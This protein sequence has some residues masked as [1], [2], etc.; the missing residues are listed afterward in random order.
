VADGVKL[1]GLPA[2]TVE[3]G[4]PEIVGALLGKLTPDGA[5]GTVDVGDV[6]PPPHPLTVS[7]TR[8]A[9]HHD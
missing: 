2:C 5:G 3:L 9:H 8:P 4:V 1:Y 6:S 7:A